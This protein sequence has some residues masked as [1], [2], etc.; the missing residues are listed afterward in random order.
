ML[1]HVESMAA[2]IPEHLDPFIAFMRALNDVK[3]ACF[4]TDYLDPNYRAIIGEFEKCVKE[5]QNKFKIS[6]INKWHITTAHLAQWIDHFQKPLGRYGEHELEGL[7]HR[8]KEIREKRFICK[9][10]QNPAYRDI[11]FRCGLAFNADST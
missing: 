2:V 8:W 5:L 1:T 7:H 4:S 6:I 9:N 3:A 10:R 11:F